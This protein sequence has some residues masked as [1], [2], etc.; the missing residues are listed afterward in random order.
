MRVVIATTQVPFVRGGAELLAEN[1]QTAIRDSGHQVE[2]VSI[3]FKWYPPAR[4]TDHM[5]ASRL[6]KIESSCGMTID[7]MIGLK[8]PAYL[9]PHAN[10][11]MWLVHQYRSA[12]DTWDGPLGDLINFPDG[13]QVR[14]AV[15]AADDRIIREFSAVYTL[16]RSVSDRLR[17]FNAIDST[18]LYHPP[19]GE[20]ALRAG[21]HEDYILVPSRIDMSKRQRLVLEALIMTRQPVRAV[22]IGGNNSPD[23]AQ[24]L[25]QRCAQAG[26][27]DRVQWLGAV[28]DAQRNEL[29]A[30][31]LSV[32][33]VP[34]DE[35]YGYVTLEAMLC[36]KAVITCTD[37]GTPLEFV[38]DGVTGFVTAPDAAEIADRLDRL[39]ADRPL[40]RRLGQAGLEDYQ[41]RNLNWYGVV[42]RLLG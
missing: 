10:K 11:V 41:H 15:Q 36:A 9:M 38:T 34:I 21:A 7:R 14:H 3:P 23:Y 18:P 24:A 5:L 6:M 32:V 33:F 39:W 4:I 29:Y 22:F 17:R 8:F 20:A 31:C 27:Q 35:D 16:S 30:Q 26:L 28:S 1:L 37:S 2:I 42:D 19:P 25:T 12:Y 13:Q 40:A